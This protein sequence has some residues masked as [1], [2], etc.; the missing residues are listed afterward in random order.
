MLSDGIGAEC[1]DNCYGTENADGDNK[2]GICKLDC[3]PNPL[4]GKGGRFNYYCSCK[5]Q[6]NAS[7]GLHADSPRKQEKPVLTWWAEKPGY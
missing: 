5:S 2:G 6:G 7:W 4:P 1:M 3:T